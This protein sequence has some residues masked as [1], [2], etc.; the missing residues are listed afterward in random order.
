MVLHYTFR[1]RAE[2]T[3]KC[4]NNE[5]ER[6]KTRTEPKLERAR[7]GVVV[8]FPAERIYSVVRE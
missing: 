8:M 4:I 5:I 7:T 6:R 3:D 1:Q 2:T